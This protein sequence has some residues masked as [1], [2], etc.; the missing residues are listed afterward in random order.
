M[1]RTTLILIIIAAVCSSLGACNR[2]ERRAQRLALVEQRK[3]QQ[4]E[5][6]E[7]RTVRVELI[8]KGDSVEAVKAKLAKNNPSGETSV[9]FPGNVETGYFVLGFDGHIPE[10]TDIEHVSLVFLDG[11]YQTFMPMDIQETE[12]TLFDDVVAGLYK[13]NNI[14]FQDAEKLRSDKWFSVRAVEPDIYDKELVLFQLWQAQRVDKK[15]STVQE[16]RYL[17]SQKFRELQE[18]RE[19]K[20]MSSELLRLGQQEA[21]YRQQQLQLQ[22]ESVRLQR[23]ALISQAIM[24]TFL[25]TYTPAYPRIIT[26]RSNSYGSYVSTTCY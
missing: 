15:E 2:A 22:Q 6:E 23:S 13:S 24:N 18:S 11:R 26:C 16:Y 17:V 25:T 10:A 21:E 1:I 5:L 3:Q 19:K 9:L 7:R 14:S 8:E 20:Q 4:A 12:L